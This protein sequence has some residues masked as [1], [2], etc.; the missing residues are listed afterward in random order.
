MGSILTFPVGF[1]NGGEA[2]V[3]VGKGGWGGWGGWGGRHTGM[4][5]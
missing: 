1:G 4:I 3:V 2:R 5:I